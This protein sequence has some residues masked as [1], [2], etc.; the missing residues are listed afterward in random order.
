MRNFIVRELRFQA[1][2]RQAWHLQFVPRFCAWQCHGQSLASHHVLAWG[3]G[4]KAKSHSRRWRPG[5]WAGC[6]WQLHGAHRELVLPSPLWDWVGW[7]RRWNRLGG[8]RWHPRDDVGHRACRLPLCLFTSA[9][10]Q[11]VASIDQEHALQEQRIGYFFAMH[12]VAITSRACVY[13]QSRP[14]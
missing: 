3:R 9:L 10:D 13:F 12:R 11:K 6:V 2:V 7:W 8:H 4:W 5:D 14:N 1:L